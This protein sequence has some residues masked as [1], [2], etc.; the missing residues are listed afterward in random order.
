MSGKTQQTASPPHVADELPQEL[1]VLPPWPQDARRSQAMS[2]TWGRVR[3]PA[4]LTEPLPWSW[5]ESE[6]TRQTGCWTAG[7]PYPPRLPRLTTPKPPAKALLQE[8]LLPSIMPNDRAMQ[9]ANEVLFSLFPLDRDLLPV[10]APGPPA[11][12]RLGNAKSRLLREIP[13]CQSTADI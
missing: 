10:S 9:F 5:I 1:T 4:P 6:D 2:R 3:K 12:Q 7:R 8:Q 11:R 13:Q